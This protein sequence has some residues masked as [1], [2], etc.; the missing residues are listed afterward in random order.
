MPPKAACLIATV[1]GLSAS[2]TAL[3]SSDAVDPPKSIS[4]FTHTSWSAKDGV[5]GPVRAIV[6]TAD[7][8]LWLGTEAGL[9]HFDGL[10]FV[11]WKSGVGERLPSSSVWSLCAARDGSVWIGLG[12]SGIS[13]LRDGRLTN[14]SP[15]EGVPGGGVLTIV[16][17]ANGTIWAGGQYGFSKFEL[18]GL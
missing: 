2:S 6:Q 14:Y 3:A 11:P 16:E 18:F 13:R 5:P 8:Y 1:L 4:Q 17:D 10:R 12:S 7:G 9:Y 15:G